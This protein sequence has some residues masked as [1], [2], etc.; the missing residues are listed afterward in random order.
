MRCPSSKRRVS[1]FASR[2]NPM[3]SA[4]G[5]LRH[6]RPVV[7]FVLS[8]AAALPVMAGGIDRHA[9]VT[10]HNV[11]CDALATTLPM[12]NGEFCFTADA[13]GL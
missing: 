12:G 8:I 6:L 4:T 9:V 2:I 5:V 11:A 3:K 13:T 7:G 1:L 10:R